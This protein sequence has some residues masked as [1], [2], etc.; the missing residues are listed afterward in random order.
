MYTIAI[1][2]N[3]A[4]DRTLFTTAWG[5][6]IYRSTDGGNNWSLLNNGQPNTRPSG[7]Y[8]SPY[9]AT[10]RTVFYI[11]WGE[12]SDGGFYISRDSGN[13][14]TA[15]NTN[16]TTRFLHHL[17]VSPNYP[18]DPTIF[19]GGERGNGGGLFALSYTVN[20]TYAIRGQVT[21]NGVGLAGVTVSGVGKT[22]ITNGSGN[23]TLS[24][25]TA[26]IST[27]T[28]FKLGYVFTP[29]SRLVTISNSDVNGITFVAMGFN[30]QFNGNMNGLLGAQGTW[31]V[32]TSALYSNTLATVS[33]PVPGP[34]YQ[35]SIY[36]NANF[37]TLDYRVQVMRSGCETCATKLFVRGDGIPAF[38]G[39]K[40]GYQFNIKR[41]GYYYV[42]KT[43][44]GTLY[45]LRNWT[46]SA[47]IKKAS[48]WNLLRVVARGSS[49]KFYINNNLV[50]SGIDSSRSTGKVGAGL[51]SNGTGGLNRLYID[52]ATLTTN[53]TSLMSVDAGIAQPSPM[54]PVRI[55][56][57][58]G[59]N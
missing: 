27:I 48:N 55:D 39:W 10:D 5:G 20:P 44:N 35:A 15:N 2:P 52:Y 22:A 57:L 11:A 8:V 18:Q 23:Y 40:N 13:I 17:A 4:N 42:G 46:Y 51:Y 24:G 33:G 19:V 56:P 38:A 50:W 32:N 43:I 9:Y 59:N 12:N 28:P 25:L 36:Y 3:Y 21:M 6:G 37:P 16:L 1:S 29:A 41:N 7:V 45:T 49:L 34:H 31:N 58:G 26:G 53:V 47:T 14:W 30:L 54:S